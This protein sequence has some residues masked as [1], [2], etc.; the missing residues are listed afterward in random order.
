MEHV[1]ML[2]AAS[3]IGTDGDFDGMQYRSL[4]DTYNYWKALGSMDDS[5]LI[6]TRYLVSE[7]AVAVWKANWESAHG[8]RPSRIIRLY[9]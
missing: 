1:W 3:R 7:A 2:D 9:Y 5:A 8:R 4:D 6:V